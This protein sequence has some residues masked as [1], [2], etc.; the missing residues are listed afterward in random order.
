VCLVE[1]AFSGFNM[2]EYGVWVSVLVYAYERGGTS[3]A[4]I[5][6]FVQLV[7]AAVAAPLLARATDR[8]DPAR[9]LRRAYWWQFA[10]LGATSLL[11]YFAT[12]DLLVYASATLAAAAVTATRPAQ[13]ALVARL[14][15]SSDELTAINVVSGW[16]ESVSILAGP[17]LAGAVIGPSGAPASIGL[18]AV[19]TLATA[20]LTTRVAS[21]CVEGAAPPPSGLKATE[22]RPR[23]APAG[24]WRQATSPRSSPCSVP[25]I[26]S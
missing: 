10:A 1:L 6:A 23:G 19:L 16:V 21:P 15:V 18:F 8:R 11:A 9:A 3:T 20:L 13:A 14:A 7:P 25:N 22:Q 4:A 26:S 24:S 17:A 2:A 5:V 12:P